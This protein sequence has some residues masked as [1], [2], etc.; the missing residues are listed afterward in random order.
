MLLL[1]RV[2][3]SYAEELDKERQRNMEDLDVTRQRYEE[4]INLLTEQLLQLNERL[5]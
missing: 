2:A 4:Q 1:Y 3:D 5:M